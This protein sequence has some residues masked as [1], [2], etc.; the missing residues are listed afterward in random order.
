MTFGKASGAL[1]VLW[2]LALS[3]FV[4]RQAMQAD[5]VR[6]NERAS[7]GEIDVER[8]NI[9]EPGGRHRLVLANESRFPGLYLEG[10]E[11]R[12]HSRSGGGMLFF[13]DEGDEVGGLSFG[14][15]R[16]ENGHSANAGLMFD[17]YKQDQ[18]IGIRY[19]ETN[20]QRVAGLQVWD[21]PDYSIKPL[22]EYSDRIAG[23]GSD[24]ERARLRQEMIDFAMAHG[25]AGAERLFAGKRLDVAM[26][27]LADKEG[28]P[29]LRL[30]VDGEGAPSVEFLDKD[31]AVVRR[32]TDE[33]SR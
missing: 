23:A 27:Q 26:V 33:L 20:G 6:T 7:F 14:S 28:R 15:S 21:R 16:T 24:E 4:M 8:L 32:L 12:H 22:M 30:Q 11:Y 29:R 19:A 10:V 31:G 1:V 25:G 9:V 18:T 13:N 2:L 17:Q 3:F 5:G